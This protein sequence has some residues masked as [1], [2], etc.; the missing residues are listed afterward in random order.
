MGRSNAH[1]RFTGESANAGAG[2]ALS[3]AGDV[4]GDGF[5]NVQDL[6]A[7]IDQ[8]GVCDDECSADFN[9]DGTVNITDLLIVLDAWGPCP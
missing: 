8:W 2:Q 7:V 6:L 4:N 3:G 5:V 1:I 9:G